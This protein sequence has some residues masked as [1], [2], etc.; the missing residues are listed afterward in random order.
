MVKPTN[1]II[2]SRQIKCKTSTVLSVGIKYSMG[3]NL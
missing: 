1:E 3:D 2:F